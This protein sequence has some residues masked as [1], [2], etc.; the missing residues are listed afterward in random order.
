MSRKRLLIVYT[1]N[2][3]F[4]WFMIG[5]LFPVFVLFQMDKG[6]DLFQLGITN[7]VRAATIIFLELPTGGLSDTIGRKRVYLMSRSDGGFEYCFF[8]NPGVEGLHE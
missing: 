3:T 6:L 8:N 1:L 4:H 2:Q 5:L 7:G